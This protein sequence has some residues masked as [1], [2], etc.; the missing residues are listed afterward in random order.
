MDRRIWRL[1]SMLR[2]KSHDLVMVTLT[3]P[4]AT[5]LASF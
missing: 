4:E 2:M 3:V 1:E 5:Q